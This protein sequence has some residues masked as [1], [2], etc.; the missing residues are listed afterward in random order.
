MTADVRSYDA[1]V[2]VG[3]GLSAFAYPMTGQLPALVWQA[4]TDVDEAAEEL[5]RR[6]QTEGSPKE[7]LG[8]HPATVAPGWQLVRELPEVRAAFQRGFVALDVER[9]PSAGHIA[10]ARLSRAGRVRMVVSYNW[11]SCLER[12]YQQEFG[13]PLPDGVL[14]KPHGDV[15]A[16]EEPW[17]LPD[18]DGLVPEAV[19]ERVVELATHPRTLLVLGYSGSDAHVAQTLLQP[20][21]VRWPVYQVGPSATGA[22]GVP[23]TADEATGALVDRLLPPLSATGWRFVGF[24]RRRDFAAALRGERL[25]P[26]DVDA[27]PEL[28]QAR[29][30]AD[31]LTAVRYATLSGGSGTGKSITAFHAARRMNGAG[32]TVVELARPG[33]ATAEDVRSFATMAGPV[34]AVVDDAQ[35]LDPGTVADF[36]AVVDDAH[37]ALLVS[38]ERL[39]GHNDE[40]VAEVRAKELI[41]KHCVANIDE[42]GPILT[43]LD[44]RVG[45]SMTQEAPLRRL[46]AANASSRDPWS[47]MF[48]ASGGERRMG[49][50]IDRL[51]EN[52]THTLV[53]A[54][55][56]AGQ[57]ASQDAGISRHD[58]MLD[59]ARVVPEAF[60]GPD[61]VLDEAAFTQALQVVQAER[62]ARENR[63]QLRTAH[64]R[65]ADRALLELTR[66]TDA[67]IGGPTRALVRNHLLSPDLSIRGKLWLLEM[68]GRSDSL[69]YTF[70][71]EW[72]D[73]DTI[74]I[75]V[76]Q[77]LAAQPGPDRSVAGRILAEVSRYFDRRHWECIAATITAWLPELTSEEVY[78]VRWILNY[79]RQDE[80]RDLHR[81][82]GNSISPSAI[83]DMLSTRG[84]RPTARA[85]S[86][87]LNELAPAHDSEDHATWSAAFAAAV[88]VEAL[89]VWLGAIDADSHPG[90]VYDLIDTLAAHA[91]SIATLALQACADHIKTSLE[92]DL[93]DATNS[94]TDWV[95]GYMYAVALIANAAG[96]MEFDDQDERQSFETW[97]PPQE[98]IEFA[99]AVLT[100][101]QQVDWARAAAS[102]TGRSRYQIESLD[103]F[104]LWLG[105]LSAGLLG[106]LAD[107][108]SFDWLTDLA[109]AACDETLSA[110]PTEL[111]TT[112]RIDTI[113]NLLDCLA[114]SA[115]G[116]ARVRRYLEE[117]IGKVDTFPFRLIKIFPDLAV[118]FLQAG[119]EVRL[120]RPRGGRWLNNVKAVEVLRDV[121]RD[122]A[123]HTLAA[124]VEQLREALESPQS[125]D[126]RELREFID[127]ADDLDRSVLDRLLSSLD[128]DTCQ[129]K[130]TKRLKDAGDDADAL[131]RRAAQVE[132]K[133]GDTA[134]DLL[135]RRHE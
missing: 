117:R 37:A 35:A 92:N 42:V 56:A 80:T 62:I 74:T 2:V 5:A 101:M 14:F 99:Q 128:A 72:L 12:A 83:A 131:V 84:T 127:V 90:E 130:W 39:E 25:R 114:A 115:P 133:V 122:S 59:I 60:G 120:E 9:E 51:A 40:T 26:T 58:V 22:D 29:S 91:P 134:R 41:Y 63:G 23:T 24:D 28:P 75:L 36:G 119:A 49:G 97:D 31:R 106:K 6:L 44:D 71:T 77:A 54:A 45:N 65:V 7:L 21:Q 109:G 129:S 79:F 55:I 105:W 102:L 135:A 88:D 4:I 85:W 123:R 112:A 104:L 57:I 110:T 113:D 27:C 124:S 126:M 17:I 111:V 100:T 1:V 47:F 38:T 10:L 50:I 64:I 69:R 34:L 70:R 43:A 86:E 67:T 33:V 103:L 48:V 107:A 95:F 108:I 98:L 116:R 53:L 125:H 19:L 76:G 121:N 68:L 30:L 52:P 93:A 94:F 16:P 8:T 20:L 18:E 87:L 81:E 82:I 118:E 3:A 78:G 13:T 15:L 96:T 66:H 132:G 32:W 11:D 61:S 73:D 46:R 89:E